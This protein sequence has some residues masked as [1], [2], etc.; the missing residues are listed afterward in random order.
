MLGIY[1]NLMTRG[2]VIRMLR[3]A[4]DAGWKT[5]VGGP[6][7]GAYAKEYLAA[8]ADAV[9]IGEGELTLEEL[10]PVLQ[11]GSNEDRARVQGIAFRDELGQVSAPRRARRL[12]ILTASRGPAANPSPSSAILK[13][14]GNITAPVP[15]P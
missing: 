3:A 5:V 6:E 10:L 9:V 1:A 2:S 14:G 13:P 15:F 4:R 7:P 11:S 8:G 12:P